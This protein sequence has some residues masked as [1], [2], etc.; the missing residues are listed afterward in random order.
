[1]TT[2][3]PRIAFATGGDAGVHHPPRE[4]D[5][6]PY[7]LAAAV[8]GFQRSRAAAVARQLPA[9]RA[10]L[11]E[12]A[13]A[14]SPAYIEMLLATRTSS[15]W[16]DPDTYY[17][18][19]SLDVA[20]AASGAGLAITDALLDDACDQAVGLWRPPGHHACTD[21]AMGFCILNN[22]A[23]AAHH[24][25][26]RGASRVLVVDWDVHHGNGTQQIFESDPRVLFISI[27]QG[28]PQ[29]PETGL[30]NETGAGEGRGFTVNI[31]LSVGAGRSAYR[32]AF[33][34]LVLPIADQYAPT[35]TFVSAGYDAHERD[36]LGGMCL[37]SEDY[38][39]LTRLLIGALGGPHAARIGFFLEGGYNRQGITESVCS[40]AD[41]L[42]GGATER[43]IPEAIGSAPSGHSGPGGAKSMLSPRHAFELDA[44]VEAQSRY[45]RIG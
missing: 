39:E 28:R 32:E 1:M 12:I 14:H 13:R 2:T 18:P 43:E 30:P 5:E 7:R 42:L 37:R 34:R 20:L 10:T 4:H 15:G 38:G 44:A 40:T 35:I 3:E 11:E 24:A 36:P 29:Y 27:H 25:L 22:V 17:T 21:Q 31:P 33:Q 9:R 23:I 16:L 41:A 8:E 19:G 45:W 6:I 26:A